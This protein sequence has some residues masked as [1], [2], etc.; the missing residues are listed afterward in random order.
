MLFSGELE[1]FLENKIR[2]C[3]TVLAE[4]KHSVTKKREGFSKR[5]IPFTYVSIVPSYYAKYSTRLVARP[6]L[7]AVEVFRSVYALLMIFDVFRRQRL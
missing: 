2:F 7:T 5:A 1:L 3:T 4:N 6:S